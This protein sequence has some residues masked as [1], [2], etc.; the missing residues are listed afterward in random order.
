MVQS[1]DKQA[2]QHEYLECKAS[3]L[4]GMNFLPV[5]DADGVKGASFG[6]MKIRNL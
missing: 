4:Y 5:A 1:H 3:V 6:M 2:A